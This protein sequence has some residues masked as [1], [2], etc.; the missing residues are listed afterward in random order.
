MHFL[1]FLQQEYYP[2]G[3]LELIVSKDMV[4]AI[5]SIVTA[6]KFIRS[7]LGN[8]KGK[9][10]LYLTGLVS[11]VYGIFQYWDDYGYMSI[12]IGL[13]A[14]AASA[15]FFRGFKLVGKKVKLEKK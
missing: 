7:M 14:G 15:G 10:A 12:L 13:I 4:I 6:T 1:T 9:W 2:P 3:F 5:G 8:I 11:V